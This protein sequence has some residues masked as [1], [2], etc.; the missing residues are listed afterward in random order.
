[1]QPALFICPYMDRFASC[2]CRAGAKQGVPTSAGL[3]RNVR[4]GISSMLSLMTSA[5]RLGEHPLVTTYMA[6]VIE[7]DILDRNRPGVRY[8]DTCDATLTFDY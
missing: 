5:P 1:M 8:D 2:T 6:F 7:Q 4:S 3:V